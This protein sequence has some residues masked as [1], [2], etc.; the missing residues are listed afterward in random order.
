MYVVPVAPEIG[1]PLTDHWL[2]LAALEVSVTLPP[3][4][5]VVALP[6]LIVGVA[7]IGLTVTAVAADEALLQPLV[8]T[9]TV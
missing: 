5:K 7:G 9:T 4:Q 1:A 6:A 2:P 3:A 8:V